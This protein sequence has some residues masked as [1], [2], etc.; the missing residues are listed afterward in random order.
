RRRQTFFSS[1]G[2]TVENAAQ[3]QVLDGSRGSFNL[4][5]VYIDCD[6]CHILRHSYVNSGRGSGAYH[7]SIARALP[8][9]C[10]PENAPVSFE[11]APGTSESVILVGDMQNPQ[12]VYNNPAFYAPGDPSY[13]PTPGSEQPSPAFLPSPGFVSTPSFVEI[14]P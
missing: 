13:A 10:L 1:P 5:A 12:G 6:N 11:S 14:E 4:T 3:Q 2:Y 9:T 7:C 8:C